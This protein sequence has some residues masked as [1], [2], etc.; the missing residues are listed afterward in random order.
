MSKSLNRRLSSMDSTFLYFE[1]KEAPLHIGST[2]VFE[3]EIPFEDFVNNLD[4][5]LHLIPRYRQKVVFD[6]FNLGHP[7]WEFDENFDIR[8]HIFRVQIDA[9]GGIKELA[10]LTCRLQEPMMERDK[11]LWDIYL[12]YGLEGGNSALVAR[13]HHCMVDGMS[14]IDLIKLIL[15]ISPE[16]KPIPPKPEFRPVSKPKDATRQLFDAILGGFEEGMNRFMEFQSGLMN[17]TEALNSPQAREAM[18]KTIGDLPRLAIP[19]PILPFNKP[20]SGKKCVAWTGFPFAEARAIRGALNGTVNDVALTVLA[21]AVSRYVESHGEKVAGK[22]L[23]VM[24]PVSLRQDDQR[25]ALGNLVSM[26]PV[27]IPL[28]IFDHAERFQHIHE[29]TSAMKSGRVAESLNL[30]SALMGTL[31]APIQALT[32]ALAQMPLPAVNIVATNVPGP[33]VPLYAMGKKMLAYYPYVPVGFAVGCSCGILSYDQTIYFGL[34]SD[35][36][37]MPDVEVLRDYLEECFAELR[38]IAGVGEI[39]QANIKVRPKVEEAIKTKMPTASKVAK[40]V[41][42]EKVVAAQKKKTPAVETESKQTVRKKTKPVLSK[43]VESKT[44]LA[45]VPKVKAEG[46]TKDAAEKPDSDQLKR[47]DTK[48]SGNK[49]NSHLRTAR[50]ENK[51]ETAEVKRKVKTTS[52][53]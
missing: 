13:V 36:N 27:E 43:I 18:Q 12:A 7:T 23:R 5:K 52:N 38:E 3:G 45:A 29:T 6:A 26:L 50:R 51:I 16:V 47:A 37:A 15:D 33:Q 1:K 17:L 48:S 49:T 40:V 39:K 11:P 32:G 20:I 30:F 28:D 14:G 19:A 35:K 34:T 9:P 42:T 8:N 22:K 2:K 24:V 4:A 25:G 46:V 31:P 10:E 21:G 44:V 41:K 53:N